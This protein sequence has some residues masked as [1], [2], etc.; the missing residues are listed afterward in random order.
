MN[1]SADN[2]PS[3]PLAVPL[4]DQL[5][6]APERACTCHPDD[7]PPQPCAKQYALQECRVL[8]YATRL[9]INLHAKHY[10]EVTQ[11]KPLPDLLGV[12][13]QIDNMTCG[14]TKA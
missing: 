14:L 10:P 13:T 8:D 3:Q 11:W 5:G 7:N 2:A 12:L 4:S 6:L 9:A 1:T